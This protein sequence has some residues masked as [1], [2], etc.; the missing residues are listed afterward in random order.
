M[1]VTLTG[2]NGYFTRMG[3]I[4]DLLNQINTFRGTTLLT[5]AQD[6]DD[7]YA[8]NRRDL[9]D[10]LYGQAAL[11][12]SSAEAFLNYLQGLAE[13][14]LIQMVYDDMGLTPQT[15][16]AAMIELVRQMTS[17]GDDVDASTIG[18]TPAYDAANNGD[19]LAV[20]TAVNGDAQSTQY[21]FDETLTLT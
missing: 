11:H 5:E 2:S 21:A 9:V 6:I 1:A 16:E 7:E 3:K 18:V 12:R 13:N 19:G 8:D 15:L 14:T 10:D 4:I 17:S 20:A